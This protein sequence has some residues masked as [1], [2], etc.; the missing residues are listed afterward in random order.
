MVVLIGDNTCYNNPSIVWN[1]SAYQFY[2][3]PFSSKIKDILFGVWFIPLYIS[4]HCLHTSG[5]LYLYDLFTSPYILVYFSSAGQPVKWNVDFLM[6]C[7]CVWVLDD[8]SSWAKV[9]SYRPFNLFCVISTPFKACN[10]Y[11]LA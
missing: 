10:T 11:H 4:P 1:I 3:S 7:L 9:N 2:Q 6:V 5:F 8:E